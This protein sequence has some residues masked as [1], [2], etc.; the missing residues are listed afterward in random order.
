MAIDWCMALNF[1]KMFVRRVLLV[2]ELMTKSVLFLQRT[3]IAHACKY[4]ITKWCHS[5]VFC[6]GVAVLTGDADY[7]R[8]RQLF[9]RQMCQRLLSGPR[10]NIFQ[11][12]FSLLALWSVTNC[13]HWHTHTRY[14][15]P[16]VSVLFMDLVSLVWWLI[17]L[18]R[19]QS[20]QAFNVYYRPT[21]RTQYATI[22]YSDNAI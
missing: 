20:Q 22:A 8:F 19:A 6:F 15:S 3:I 14:H 11:F 12:C 5:I 9:L 4:N 7:T 18:S 13:A 2:R 10:S 1:T 17:S 21:E 16:K